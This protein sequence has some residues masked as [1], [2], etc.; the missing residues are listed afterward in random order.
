MDFKQQQELRNRHYKREPL[1][2]ESVIEPLREPLSYEL[3]LREAGESVSMRSFT[4]GYEMI[5]PWS[6][7]AVNPTISPT[8][9]GS[10][11]QKILNSLENPQERAKAMSEAYDLLKVSAA[12]PSYKGDL[13]EFTSLQ[14][15]LRTLN[16]PKKVSYEFFSDTPINGRTSWYEFH[17]GV[18]QGARIEFLP[19]FSLAEWFKLMNHAYMIDPEGARLVRRREMTT[20]ELW[21]SEDRK[22]CET[23]KKLDKLVNKGLDKIF[24]KPG[25]FIQQAMYRGKFDELFISRFTELM[26]SQFDRVERAT[27]Y[28]VQPSP[29]LRDYARWVNREIE[30]VRSILDEYIILSQI[31]H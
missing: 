27:S 22:F 14:K 31:G 20:Y 21:V 26:E 19:F 28:L 25:G 2:P 24:L 12:K 30:T 9:Y 6:A 18:L 17:R 29:A 10:L 15:P 5:Y 11:I 16:S 8:I 4:M 1:F 23:P 13:D 7:L 3:K